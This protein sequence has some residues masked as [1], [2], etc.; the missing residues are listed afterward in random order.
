M[1]NHKSPP[2]GLFVLGMHRSG[3]SCLAGMLNCAGF[4]LG[5]VDEWNPDNRKGN[6][7]HLAVTPLNEGIL[8]FAGGSWDQPPENDLVVEKRHQREIN[9]IIE[10]L[11]AGG[12]PWLIKDPRILLLAKPWLGARSD[13]RHFG[14]FRHPLAVA[15]SLQRRDKIEPNHAVRLWTRYNQALLDL[16][17]VQS[18]PLMLFTPDPEHLIRNL[19]SVLETQ[20]AGH[21]GGDGIE[22]DKS[23]E[24]FSAD[25]VHHDPD[26]LTDL[27]QPLADAGID[28]DIARTANAVWQELIKLQNPYPLTL[29]EAPS[30]PTT[31]SP[32]DEEIT[33]PEIAFE[34][35]QDP[36]P[37]I[38]DRIR[39]LQAQHA[40]D[41]LHEWLKGWQ[42]R[43]PENPFI[44]WELARIE[45]D[46]GK[47]DEAMGHTQEAVRLAPGWVVPLASLGR[48]AEE[49]GNW[50]VAAQ[51]YGRLLAAHR[52]LTPPAP[53]NAQLFFDHGEGFSGQ[54]SLTLPIETDGRRLDLV[55]EAGQLGLNTRR[56]RLDPA[57][58]QVVVTDLSLALTNTD[59]QVF[60]LQPGSD[61]A[62]MQ[63]GPERFFVSDD[64][65]VTLE[66]LPEGMQDIAKVT[67]SFRIAYVGEEV[68]PALLRALNELR[69]QLS[70]ASELAHKIG[71]LDEQL[72]SLATGVTAF[73]GKLNRWELMENQLATLE[74]RV[75]AVDAVLGNVR[76]SLSAR[77]GTG[78]TRTLMNPLSLG[79]GRTALDELDKRWRA[80]ESAI[81]SPDAEDSET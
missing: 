19:E 35:G 72:Q 74:Q 66:G 16:Q 7:E 75:Q 69:S 55:F 21:I 47:A 25:L 53:L 34:Q 71:R 59:G 50:Q 5:T 31:P 20:F 32:V 46:L 6:R 67:A 23:G 36:V 68:Q 70:D 73:Q 12:K 17:Q 44:N 26:L 57:N 18:F 58:Q 4:N 81:R 49:T 43:L 77:L 40:F 2:P 3:T 52:S 54:N 64:P 13:S 60:P 30:G 79:R 63:L 42:Q 15:R 14:I 38:R 48:W 33:D 45:W 9:A 11:E 1:S 62:A 37:L 22:P 78:V 8:S 24:F 56:L 80:L 27:A 51:C 41:E 65:Q 39:Q 76:R 10:N 61:N 28:S 29:A